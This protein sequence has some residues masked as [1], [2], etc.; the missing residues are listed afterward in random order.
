M[1][2]N[3]PGPQDALRTSSPA[4]PS[5]AT[6]I[7][8]AIVVVLAVLLIGGRFGWFS[9][10][11]PRIAG[12]ALLVLAGLALIVGGVLASMRRRNGTRGGHPGGS[13]G[14]PS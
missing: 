14:F 6:V 10:V 9:I 2:T 1:S 12:V 7:W 11:E 13:G 4:G 8:G 3:T 5:L